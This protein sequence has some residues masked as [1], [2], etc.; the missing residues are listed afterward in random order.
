MW[1]FGFVPVLIALA[2]GGLAC[3]DKGTEPQVVTIPAR[4]ASASASDL[5]SLLQSHPVVFVGT[6]ARLRE[7]IDVPV[8]KG[9]A[10]EVQIPTSLF[11]VLVERPL[12]GDSRIGEY[13]SIRQA[14]G[15]TKA[16]DGTSLIVT[17]EGDEIL[18]EGQTYLF[19]ASPSPDGVGLV[20]SPFARL[21]VDTSNRLSPLREWSSAGALEQLA[22]LPA[23][24]A[25]KVI[26]RHVTP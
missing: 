6:V 5:T 12:T 4:W 11:S 24:R 1:R 21:R 18:E 26:L 23:D 8:L 14:G 15:P 19:F 17:L 7:T 9:T 3:G 13:V 16:A 25:E 22:D 10:G 2:L 20:T